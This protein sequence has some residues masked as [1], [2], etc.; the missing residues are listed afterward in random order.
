ME[1]IRA[2]VEG[3]ESVDCKPEDCACAHAFVRRTDCVRY[4]GDPVDGKP[5]GRGVMAWTDGTR[6]V[7]E[8]RSG[9]EH[10]QG[11]LTWVQRA[12]VRRGVPRRAGK[13]AGRLHAGGY[14]G[15][16]PMAASLNLALSADERRDLA[17]EL[18][19]DLAARG[20]MSGDVER[21][22]PMVV[23]RFRVTVRPESEPPP[24][25]DGR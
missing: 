18:A 6:H 17:G 20:L 14:G 21:L 1:Q 9:L 4:E 25:R 5:Q 24:E 22:A 12:S 16:C 13:R 19:D 7:G 15:G 10:G 11:V 23:D 8:F 2:F 3:C